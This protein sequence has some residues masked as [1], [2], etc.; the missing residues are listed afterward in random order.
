MQPTLLY[1]LLQGGGDHVTSLFQVSVIHYYT[2]NKVKLI[3]LAFRVSII[4]V[5]LPDLAPIA[6]F[7]TYSA[8]SSALPLAPAPEY[9]FTPIP[10][11]FFTAFLLLGSLPSNIYKCQN[12]AFFVRSCRFLQ[13]IINLFHLHASMCLC[14]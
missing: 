6:F 8:P 11:P 10:M 5:Q 9:S 7:N 1:I 13:I 2:Q 4:L 14:L 12:M 3:S